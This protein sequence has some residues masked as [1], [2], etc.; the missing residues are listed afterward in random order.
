MKKVGLFFCWVFMFLMGCEHSGLNRGWRFLQRK[1]YVQAISSLTTYISNTK[2]GDKNVGRMASAF[3]YRGLSQQMIGHYAEA[4]E[5]YQ[6]TLQLIPHFYYASFNIGLIKLRCRCFDES[7]AWF[8]K[9]WGIICNIE[10]GQHEYFSWFD[11]ELLMKDASLCYS[12]YLMGLLHQRRFSEVRKLVSGLPD[13]LMITDEETRILT[14]KIINSE[15]DWNVLVDISVNWINKDKNNL[16]GFSNWM[17]AQL[18]NMA[19]E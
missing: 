15:E 2:T 16:C 19:G 18:L 13:W 6:K 12:Y 1:N 17:K 4:E 7:T 3:F 10:C 11:D 9:T 8:G 14:E 5:D